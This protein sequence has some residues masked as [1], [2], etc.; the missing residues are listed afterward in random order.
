MPHAC[1]PQQKEIEMKMGSGVVMEIEI[2]RE[3]RAWLLWRCWSRVSDTSRFYI[4]YLV[5][6]HVSH[7]HPD[8]DKDK[9]DMHPF[10][11]AQSCTVV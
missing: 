3:G 8:G 9:E 5:S 11:S 4:S 6:G 7:S 2:E 10:V 1:I